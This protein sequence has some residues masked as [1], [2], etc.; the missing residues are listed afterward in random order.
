MV[1]GR[2]KD[3][4]VCVLMAHNGSSPFEFHASTRRFMEA[5]AAQAAL[6][7][8]NS[9]LF[10]ELKANNAQI[11]GA[12]QKLR[13]LDEL[14]AKFAHGDHELRTPLTLI[15]GYDSMLAESAKPRLSEDEQ[16]MLSEAMHSCR[17]LIHL[18]NTMLDIHRIEAGKME[19]R[20]APADLV[21]MAN[22][23]ETLFQ[24]E[25]QQKGIHL[26]LQVPASLRP[27]EIDG[28][29]VSR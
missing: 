18:V 20:L 19:L 14:N 21:R 16:E 2:C 15:L 7:V 12:N 5:L 17:R 6:A 22:R 9:R 23:V 8:N 27:V 29:R 26:G 25:A 4:L 28:E 24:T 10:K 1:P 11:Q 13:D 3:E